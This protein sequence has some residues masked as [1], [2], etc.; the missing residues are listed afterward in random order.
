MPRQH[1]DEVAWALALCAS[2]QGPRSLAPADRAAA[3][4]TVLQSSTV[5]QTGGLCMPWPELT[6]LLLATIL[7]FEVLSDR[8]ATRSAGGGAQPCGVSRPSRRDL[9]GSLSMLSD[10]P[11]WHE[12]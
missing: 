8:A 10:L 11:T 1:V 12:V 9:A 6:A 4:S 2:L 7:S 3:C 5:L